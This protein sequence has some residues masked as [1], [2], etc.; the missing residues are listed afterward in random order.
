MR[1]I[2]HADTIVAIATPPGKGA[3]GIVRLSGTLTQLIAQKILKRK[4]LL[5]HQKQGEGFS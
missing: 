4:K 1:M 5:S 3:V 2:I